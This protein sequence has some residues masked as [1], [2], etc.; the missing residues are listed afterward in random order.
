VAFQR[1]GSPSKHVD[2]DFGFDG[3]DRGITDYSNSTNIGINNSRFVECTT[4]GRLGPKT[5]EV[6]EVIY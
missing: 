4:S 3:T 5:T 2:S 1:L 6:E